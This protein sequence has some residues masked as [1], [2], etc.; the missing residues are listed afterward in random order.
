MP[1][2]LTE[3]LLDLADCHTTLYYLGATTPPQDAA[4]LPLG[5]AQAYGG[6][7][8][9]V[10]AAAPAP[11][12][13]SDVSGSG[14]PGGIMVKLSPVYRNNKYWRRYLGSGDYDLYHESAWES[15]IP[16]EVSLSLR[17]GFIPDARFN[18][19]VSLIPR[20]LLYP[21]G[22]SAWLSL[23]VTGKHT[24]GEL[25][26]LVQHIFTA[27]AFRLDPDP[28]PPDKQ[29]AAYFLRE[30][31]NVIARGVRDDAFGGNKTKDFDSQETISVTTV[32]GKHGGSPSLGALK[33]AVQEEIL[34]IVKPEGPAPKGQLL[35]YVYRRSEEDLL[36]YLVMSDHKR[37]I[38]LEHLLV[39]IERNR[40]HLLCYH[41]NTFHS[42]MQFRQLLDLL[43]MAGKQKSI[44]D[45][46]G[47]LVQTA[48]RNL[49][50]PNYANAS[51]KEFLKNPAVAG[52]INKLKK[53]DKSGK[54]NA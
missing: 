50:S 43:V 17:V 12:A 35:D 15:I 49:E 40:D 36:E 14:A 5:T 10:A 48:I 13:F 20:V 22:W 7:Y 6:L 51:V 11:K 53:T 25:S 41:N 44:S 54:G 34:R 26:S 23:R 32:L 38:W 29:P 24:L 16:I 39:P 30:V 45:P 52:A 28:A 19:K 31:F 3:T 46:L 21:F 1:T 27:K 4:P 33:P 9:T 37:F 18:F 2:T 8:Q 47:E 42:L